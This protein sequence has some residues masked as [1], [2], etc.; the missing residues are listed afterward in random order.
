MVNS[1]M[2]VASQSLSLDLNL[3]GHLLDGDDDELRR[4]ERREAD[5]HVDD[6][7]RLILRGR[8]LR[9]GLDE[10]GFAR[11]AP[12]ERALAEEAV[13]EGSGGEANL[14]PQRLVVRL[15]DGEAQAPHEALLDEER[16]A[17]GAGGRG[18]WCRGGVA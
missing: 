14:R 11:R 13:H 17:A 6:A 12:G 18:V 3:T 8:R 4:P 9:V 2:K 5:Q 15:E 1:A 7:E 10:V 16:E